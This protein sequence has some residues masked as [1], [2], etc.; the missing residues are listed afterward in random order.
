[1][2]PN[3]Q[4]IALQR[5][6]MQIP[7]NVYLETDQ[8]EILSN[9]VGEI[10]QAVLKGEG[11]VHCGSL[12]IILVDDKKIKE[13]NK[14]FLNK[15]Q[16]TDV[17]AFVLDEKDE[18]DWGEVYIS[19]DRA[20]EQARIFNTSWKEELARYVIH[21]I[22]HLLGYEDISEEAK[23]IMRKREEHYLDSIILK[24]NITIKEEK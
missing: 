22:L 2:M 24:N 19:L 10:S 7:I 4:K 6:A 3:Q 20:R 5:M 21:G 23:S 9:W 16:P 18:D 14:Q 13:I 15:E 8:D 17:I 12:S 1:M 11:F